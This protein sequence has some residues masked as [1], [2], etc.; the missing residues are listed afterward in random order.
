MKKKLTDWD[1]TTLV[2]AWRYYEHGR[3]IASAMFP[4]EVIERFFTG[5][6]DPESEM[7][8][9]R[10]FADV[11]HGLRGASDWDMHD[12]CD[13]KPWQKFYYF[14]KAYCDG[15]VDVELID[16]NTV[17]AF[18]NP[19]TDRWIPVDR[20]ISR[21]DTDIFIAPDAIV[22]IKEVEDGNDR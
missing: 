7:R 3:T 6:Y 20:Y 21:P 8:I 11:D 1:W 14:C 13:K 9:A 4:A 17:K 2:A 16:G 18:Y 5:K 22:K 15:F 19:K 12:D 10:Q